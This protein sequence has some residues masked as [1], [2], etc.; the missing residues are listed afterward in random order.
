M[1]KGSAQRDAERQRDI[2][3]AQSREDRASAV[4]AREPIRQRIAGRRKAIDSK[5]FDT[6][7]DFIGNNAIAAEA[8]KRMENQANLTQT[9]IAG[10]SS[11]YASADTVQMSAQLLKDRQAQNTGAQYETDVNNYI[12]DTDNMETDSG[13]ADAGLYTNF[14]ESGRNAAF[15]NQQLYAQ[16][17]MQKAQVVPQ[18]IGA[19]IGG[20]GSALGGYFSK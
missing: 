20:V 13:N 7:P 10:L 8:N 5:Q 17:A 6:A 11:K 1:G 15:Q 19:T 12:R 2:E 4:A 14:Y 16:I 3:R 18:L 9:G